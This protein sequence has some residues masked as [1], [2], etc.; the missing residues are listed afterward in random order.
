MEKA[1]LIG[2]MDRYRLVAVIRSKSSER[3]LAT[4][5]AIAEGGVRF[6]EITLSVPGAIG[7]IETLSKRSDLYVGSGTVLSDEQAQQA[8]SA[9]AQFIVSP[10]LEL[11]LIS[12]C[13]EAGIICISGAATPTEII[14]ARRAGADLVK[15]FPADCVG[16]PHFVRQMLGPLPDIR[17]MVSGGVNQ[18][19]VKE[20]VELGVI[21]V[22]LGSALLDYQ[23]SEGGHDGLV[24]YARSFVKLVD[25]ALGASRA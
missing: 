13:H 2:E 10:T 21:G 25:E 24:R 20:Y 11:S 7:V 17:F 3:A 4:V 9:G 23:L 6:A 18:D 12:I 16:G 14:T 22:V 19:N 1:G 5:Q 8:I 15:I